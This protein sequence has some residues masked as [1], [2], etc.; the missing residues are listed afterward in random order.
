M[1]S[2][3]GRI[4]VSFGIAAAAIGAILVA[5]ALTTDP[6]R[7]LFQRHEV[8]LARLGAELVAAAREGAPLPGVEGPRA[9]RGESSAFLFRGGEGPMGGGWVPPAV[10][11]LALEAA[12]TGERNVRAGRNGLWLALPLEDDYVL[13]AEVP[14]PSRL[15]RLLDPYGLILRLGAALGVVLAVSWLLARSLAAPIREL[16]RATRRLA[17]GD[18]GA[19]VSDALGKRADE[20]AELGRDFDR[21]AAR[22]EELLEA[23]RRL[24]RDISHELRSPLARLGVALE[25]ARRKAGS[26]AAADLDRIGREAERLNELIGQ[27]LTLTRLEGAGE[28]SAREEADVVRLVQEVA[29]DADFEARAHGRTVEL[30]AW[31][32]VRLVGNPELLRRAVENVVRNAVRFTAEGTAVTLRLGAAA[33]G[34]ARIEV[35]DRGP[36]L[37]EAALADVFRPFY[38]VADARDRGSGGV[39]LG[40]AIAERAVRLHGG[41]I[42]AQNRREG[43]LRV[44][45]ELPARAPG[46]RQPPP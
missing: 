11:R 23:Q 36:G 22:I 9:R 5:L 46:S 3:F 31:E 42:R 37:P 4:F 17:S 26:E 35:C 38:R 32:P 30:E 34:G 20:T 41:S 28:L 45:I 43:G 7:A 39:G 12:A 21:M 44:T 18:L 27:L 19:R 33:G 25:L 16:R 24:L 15:D 40:L 1:R 8:Q 14:P 2:L 13:V 10:R 6:R 29:R